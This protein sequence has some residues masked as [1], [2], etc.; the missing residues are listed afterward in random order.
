MAKG[1]PGFGGNMGN[2]MKQAE[3]MQKDIQK[4]QGELDERL[5][6]ASSGG[7]AVSVVVNG[8]KELKEIKIKPEVIDPDDIEMLQ[9]LIIAAVNEGS[10][11]ADELVNSEMRRVTGGGL[12]GLF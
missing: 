9:D 1:F 11:K 7:G 3:K 4:L 5:V 10:R 2:L 6:E 12:P 8:K